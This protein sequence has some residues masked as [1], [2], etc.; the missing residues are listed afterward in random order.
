[1]I[2]VVFLLIVAFILWVSTEIFQ[3]VG[4]GTPAK[5]SDILEMLEI[6]GNDY[7]VNKTWNLKFYLHAYR[8]SAPPIYQTTN[9]LLFPYYI[10]G[11][12]M[13]PFW[14]KSADQIRELFK[15]KLVDSKYQ[16]TKR[17][18]LGLK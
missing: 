3:I 7:Q 4:E 6:R 1:M 17:D 2:V 12:G 18:K 13:V 11:V 5:D 10:S 16:V 14:Y 9:S 15:D 8:N